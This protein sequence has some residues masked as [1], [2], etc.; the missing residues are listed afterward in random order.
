M[1]RMRW[2][3]R[4]APARRKC[5]TCSRR[6]R[7]PHRPRPGRGFAAR[8]FGPGGPQQR[9][10]KVFALGSGRRRA[11]GFR[12][13]G[14]LHA[15][16]AG[17]VICEIQQNS[18]VT[19]RLYDF[20]RVDGGGRP[21]PLHVDRAA[22]VADVRLRPSSAAAEASTAGGVCRVERLAR[23]RYFAGER[24]SWDAGFE[25]RPDP[26]RVHI[27]I[28]LE[29]S[30]SLNRTPF[31]PGDC[32]LIPAEAAPFLVAGRGVRAIRAFVP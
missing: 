25:Y 8:R 1:T 19:Y 18:D 23:C 7:A 21:R 9:H 10:R 24:L 6:N 30:G 3:T 5:G 15:L 26:Q 31:Q 27:L 20:G 12:S 14:T 28:V 13:A 11:D 32:F 4:T 16:G 17:V 2:R 22:Q 29:G